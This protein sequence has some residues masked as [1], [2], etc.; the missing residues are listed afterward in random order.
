MTFTINKLLT[1]LVI[2]TAICLLV[3]GILDKIRSE[4]SEDNKLEYSERYFN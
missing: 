1:I 2:T 3:L 4:K